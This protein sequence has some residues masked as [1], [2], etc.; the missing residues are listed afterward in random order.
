MT[1]MRAKGGED[2]F[3]L[4]YSVLEELIQNNVS[5]PEAYLALWSLEYSR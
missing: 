2:K 1:Y 3:H 5:R 4:G